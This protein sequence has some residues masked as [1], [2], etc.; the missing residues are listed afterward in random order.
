MFRQD[1][2]RRPLLMPILIAG[3]REES[4]LPGAGTL[5]K[6]AN[7]SHERYYL[8]LSVNGHVV[9][10]SDIVQLKEGFSMDLSQVFR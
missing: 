1:S 9:G 4:D 2:W 5:G 8:E 3:C 10:N 6:R 7:I